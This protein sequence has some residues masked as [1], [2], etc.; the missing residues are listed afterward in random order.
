[1]NGGFFSTLLEDLL[2]FALSLVYIAYLDYS[3][4]N[5]P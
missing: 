3:G 2:D 5:N 4:K 1:V